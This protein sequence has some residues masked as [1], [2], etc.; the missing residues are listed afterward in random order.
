[1]VQLHYRHIYFEFVDITVGL[2]SL[3]SAHKRLFREGVDC[4]LLPES[5]K[6]N[7]TSRRNAIA[8]I[9]LSRK[10]YKQQWRHILWQLH[11]MELKTEEIPG[12][13]CD[14][15]SFPEISDTIHLI[16]REDACNVCQEEVM[17]IAD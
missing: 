6:E 10:P 7:L 13:L 9:C 15:A 3:T 2:L 11:T 16:N 17:T 4:S 8:V 14:R 12:R 1:M 5:N